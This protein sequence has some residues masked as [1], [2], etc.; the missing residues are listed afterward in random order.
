MLKPTRTAALPRDL[1]V[2]NKRLTDDGFIS[3][4]IKGERAVPDEAVRFQMLPP[5]I[6]HPRCLQK[7][8]QA[9]EN[10]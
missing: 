7:S 3:L 6:P 9:I 5:G 8:P 2:E 4:T 10:K 1:G